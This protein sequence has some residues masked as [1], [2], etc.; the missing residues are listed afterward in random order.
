MLV[1]TVFDRIKDHLPSAFHGFLWTD[2]PARIYVLDL[3]KHIR[4]EAALYHLQWCESVGPCSSLVYPP[5]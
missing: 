1:P 2:T 5:I 3:K 4:L